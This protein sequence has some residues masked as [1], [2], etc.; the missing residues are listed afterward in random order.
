MGCC[1]S[2]AAAGDIFTTTTKPGKAVPQAALST[3]PVEIKDTD[4]REMISSTTL[5][6]GLLWFAGRSR[7][8]D[9]AQLAR[10]EAAIKII[11]VDAAGKW[12]AIKWS[13]VQRSAA[14]TLL[15]PSTIHQGDTTLC[16]AVSVLEAM[17]MHRPMQYSKLVLAVWSEAKVIGARGQP[18][19]DEPELNP[20]LL[21]S[22]PVK[23]IASASED[24]YSIADWMVATAMIAELKDQSYFRDMLGHD[25]YLG[26]DATGPNGQTVD[27]ERGLTS[28]WDVKKMLIE[29]LGCGDVERY[30]SY[31]IARDAPIDKMLACTASGAFERGE[32]VCVAAIASWFWNAACKGEEDVTKIEGTAMA[33]HFVRV[34]SVEDVGEQMLRVK[35][36]SYGEVQQ[37]TVKR[38]GFARCLFD[39]C[40]GN[41]TD[42]P[43]QKV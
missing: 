43:L 9:G 34:R 29:L 10:V 42:E 26:Q 41:L 23:S 3:E 6:D 4:L 27:L 32:V 12:S 24:H 16:G 36:F 39:S 25:E 28:P 38:A 5:R 33:D 22:A 13:D 2:L 37:A 1:H 17:A 8:L 31:W 14:A 30:V 20:A 35:V 18:W 19:G 7:P 11:D 21:A 15:M 40:F